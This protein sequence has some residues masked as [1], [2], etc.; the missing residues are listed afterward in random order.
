MRGANCVHLS[1]PARTWLACASR[2][3]ASLFCAHDPVRKPDSTFPDHVFAG[4]ESI[5]RAWWQA[6]LGHEMSRERFCISS[7]P[8]LTR[9]SMRTKPCTQSGVLLA[10][11]QHGPRV[12]PGGDESK[13][14]GRRHCERQRSNPV[15]CARRWNASSLS[16]LAMTTTRGTPGPGPTRHPP[17]CRAKL[18]VKIG[19]DYPS[20]RAPIGPKTR[21]WDVNVT[22]FTLTSAILL[23]GMIAVVAS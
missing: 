6:E 13:R 11:S 12:K 5:F 21:V 2:R 17:N 20:F 23:A 18:P 9:Q 22:I 14:K 4:G 8:G 1:V 19:R 16:L 15:A 10:A 3:F 7:L